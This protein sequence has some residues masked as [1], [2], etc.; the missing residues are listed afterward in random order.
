VYNNHNTNVLLKFHADRDLTMLKKLVILTTIASAS[1]AA[2]S[3]SPN[4]EKGIGNAVGLNGEVAN[5]PPY[6]MWTVQNG[7]DNY[8]STTDEPRTTN[9][10]QFDPHPIQESE[11]RTPCDPVSATHPPARKTQTPLSILDTVL[12]LLGLIL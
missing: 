9:P 1:A 3:Q 4:T 6:R 12:H 5:T 10:G 11:P 7:E 2:S 8:F